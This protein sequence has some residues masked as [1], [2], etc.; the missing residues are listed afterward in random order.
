MKRNL[1]L[2]IEDYKVAIVWFSVNISFI[3]FG[4]LGLLNL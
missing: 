1:K 2:F 4:I 3:A